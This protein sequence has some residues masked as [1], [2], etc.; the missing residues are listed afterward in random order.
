MTS[1][2]EANSSS[3]PGSS[4]S[5]VQF[6]SIEGLYGYRTVTLSSNYA[7]T[8]LIAKNGAGKTTLL[9][10]L[11]AFLRG[12]F[13]RLGNLQ[14]SRIRCRLRGVDEELVLH[15]EDIQSLY[16]LPEDSEIYSLARRCNLD[17][18]ALLE[19]ILTDYQGSRRSHAELHEHDVFAKIFS[20]VGH[21]SFE[22]RRLIERLIDSTRGH[23][24]N[25]QRIHS[26]LKAAIGETEIVYLPTYRR[27]ELP[28]SDELSKE[29]R[30]R[31]R[32]RPSIQSRLGL[33]K[34]GLYKTDIQFGLADI[35]ERLSDLNQ[36]IL[37]NSNQGYREISANIIN[38][39][40]D[41]TFDDREESRADEKPDR[42]SL[43][44]FF[45]RVKEGRQFAG[46]H[47]DRDFRI[48]DIDRVYNEGASS[49]TS[50]KFLQYFLSKLNTVIQAT[51]TIEGLVEEFI[52]HCNT[53]LSAQDPTTAIG[54]NRPSADDKQLR[55]DRKT[56]KVHVESLA[57]Q[58]K[59]PLDS[60][61]SGEKQMIS[62]FARL[63]LY[64]GPKIL[65][66]DEPELSL[67]IDWQRKILIDVVNA[68]TCSQ[69]IAITHSPFV[70]ENAL[71]PYAQSIR[72]QINLEAQRSAEEDI[73]DDVE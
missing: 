35:S 30:M 26:A 38:E 8:I 72:L 53:Y 36:E 31:G 44:L 61:S 6:F 63:Y 64:T 27:I 71:E 37:F 34:R 45:S 22:A 1:E 4:P 13:N 5:I 3:R 54:P 59:I 68:P 62:L 16:K 65:L 19:Y 70:F 33:S 73:E 12:E 55:L 7:A 51:R 10:A 60:L 69:V 66:I 28:L 56:L 39:L 52:D 25:V 9:G 67:S 57:A 29:D 15:W 58:R 18:A 17:P 48:P 42:E 20:A 41:G 2:S 46:P 43:L 23:N 11:D 24:S 40:L 14:F 50:N 47:R 32:R 49:D 21:S